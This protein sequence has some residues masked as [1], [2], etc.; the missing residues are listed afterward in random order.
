V[1][2]ISTQSHEEQKKANSA[3]PKSTTGLAGPE[4]N[5]GFSCQQHQRGKSKQEGRRYKE[6]S[7]GMKEQGYGQDKLKKQIQQ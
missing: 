5:K 1:G 2:K 6:R 3:A 7:F 4:I